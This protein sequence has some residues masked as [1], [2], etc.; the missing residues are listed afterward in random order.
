MV[1]EC[2]FLKDGFEFVR[3]KGDHKSYSKKGI[4]RPVVIPTYKE[5]D[6]DI[7]KSNMRTAGMSREQY[8]KYLNQCK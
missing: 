4:A 8:F 3:Q 7:I 5:I 2:I 1:L 6:T